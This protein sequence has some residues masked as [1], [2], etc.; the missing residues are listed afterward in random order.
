MSNNERKREYDEE[1]VKFCAN[2]YSLKVKYE[3]AVDADCC[4]ECGSLNIREANIREWERLYE[5]RYGRKLIEGES[6]P[7]KSAYFNMSIEKLKKTL[8]ESK[9]FNEIVRAL[10]PSFPQG[11]SKADSMVLLFDKLTK[12]GRIDALRLSLLE[13]N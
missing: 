8:Y 3:D 11:I 5:E 9:H 2:C 13:Y 10:Y 6:N 12:E 7:R 1:P 4:A